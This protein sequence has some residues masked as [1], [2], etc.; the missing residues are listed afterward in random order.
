CSSS[1]L[2]APELVNIEGVCRQSVN[3]LNSG[4]SKLTIT[5]TASKLEPLRNDLLFE[6]T[7]REASKGVEFCSRQMKS[8]AERR[9]GIYAIKVSG[10][11]YGGRVDITQENME[12]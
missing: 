2:P 10:V 5:L 1:R 11:R 12:P 6:Q 8:C 7:P 4:S 3:N 9:P